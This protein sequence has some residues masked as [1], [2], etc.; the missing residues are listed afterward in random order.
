[1]AAAN[2]SA[3]PRESSRRGTLCQ[4]DRNCALALIQACGAPA[5]IEAALGIDVHRDGPE[6]AW[7]WQGVA[8]LVGARE[9]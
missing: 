8:V 4:F 5:R 1:M 3:A 9:D 2:K 6:P 7:I